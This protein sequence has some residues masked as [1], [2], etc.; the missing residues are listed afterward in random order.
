MM[1]LQEKLQRHGR[2]KLWR[3]SKAAVDPI[4]VSSGAAI[5]AV[6]NLDG[7]HVAR[8]FG[9]PHAPQF[10]QHRRCRAGN[11]LGLRTKGFGDA[12]QHARKTRHVVAICGWKIRASVK[13]D[14]L[15]SKKHGHGPA[16]MSGH[17]L[18]GAH[19]D[20]IEVRPFFTVHLDI[21]EVLIHQPGNLFVFK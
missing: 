10:A 3:T 5:S 14:A 4:I 16:T 1:R 12:Q 9:Q 18:D 6:E 2:W 13:G 19:V 15:R 20:L 7:Q 8:F 21:D 17:H 11:L